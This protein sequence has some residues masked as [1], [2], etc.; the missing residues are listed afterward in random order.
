MTGLAGVA[1]QGGRPPATERSPV[2]PVVGAHAFVV[3]LAPVGVHTGGSRSMFLSHID[4]TFPLF[5]PSPSL[6]KQINL[7]VYI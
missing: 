6:K 7:K 3:G 4:V 2:R 1:R 5:L